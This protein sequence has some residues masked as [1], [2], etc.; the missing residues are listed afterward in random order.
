MIRQAHGALPRWLVNTLGLFC[1]IPLDE[2]IAGRLHGCADCRRMRLQLL[3]N[4][5]GR[6]LQTLSLGR[7]DCCTSSRGKINLKKALATCM[8]NAEMDVH[9]DSD[10]EAGAGHHRNSSSA[11]TGMRARP[12]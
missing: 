9:L 6:R 11:K 10:A 8:P 4:A 1:A 7:I 5:A 3:L 2:R 12:I